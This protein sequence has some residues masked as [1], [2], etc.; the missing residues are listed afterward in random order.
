MTAPPGGPD[1][2][3]ATATVVAYR[4][5]ARR[6]R[7]L[8]GATRATTYAYDRHSANLEAWEL[9]L[10]HRHPELLGYLVEER[11]LIDRIAANDAARP[12]LVLRLATTRRNIKEYLRTCPASP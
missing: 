9:Q 8:S 5:A 6:I 4:E 11:G 10:K 3:Y 12:E 7:R 1:R 2:A